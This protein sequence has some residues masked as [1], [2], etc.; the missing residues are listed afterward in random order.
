MKRISLI[1]SSLL[2]A[3]STLTVVAMVYLGEQFARL[4]FVPFDIFDW[5]TRVLPGAWITFAIDTIVQVVTRLH[6]G[7]TSS[8][9]KLVELTIAIVQFI[10]AG[11]VFSLILAL[12]GRR[13]PDKLVVFG[14]L[15]GLLLFITVVPIEIWL[16]FTEAGPLATLIWLAVVFVGWG[17]GLGRLIRDTAPQ[18]VLD[19]VPRVSR[20]QFLYLAGAGSFTVL[21]TALGVSLTSAGNGLPQT[22]Q[23]ADADEIVGA[24][25]TSGPS[26]SPPQEDLAARFE[27]VPGTRLEL[28]S[29]NDFY[30]VDINTRPPQIDGETWR[31]ELG[32]LVLSPLSLSLEELRS[33]PA[34]SQVITLSCI[35]NEVGGDLISTGLWT[36]VRLKDV[37]E[38][39]GLRRGAQEIYIEAVDGFYES[40]PIEEAM[41]D[42]TLLV[43]AMNGEPLPVE[44][45]FPLRIYIPNHYGMKQPKWI[46]RMEVID[47]EG[48]GYWVDRGWNKE[49]IVKTTSVVDTIT[50]GDIDPQSSLVPVGGIAFAGARRISKVEVQVDDGLWEVAELRTP[51]LSPLSWVQWRYEWLAER[52]RH[53]FRVRAYDGTGAL[54]EIEPHA[55]HP[56][57]ATGIHSRTAQV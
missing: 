54:Q 10:L 7:S 31:L 46:T 50:T 30:R 44:H 47:H 51:P 11:V 3:L 49:A 14:A 17:A 43:Y 13:W 56:N 41:D 45:G 36:G 42:R 27:P 20:R 32:G 52:G 4:P 23:G 9:A 57:G 2:G 25:N 5:M 29:N 53:T 18:P 35:S 26:A 39:A 15:G 6:L 48:E 55:P 34:V 37:L 33:R 12:L 8:T 19:L 21:V 22:G 24:N 38:E 16:G 1:R 40:V 28:S